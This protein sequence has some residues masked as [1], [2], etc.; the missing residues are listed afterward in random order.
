MARSGEVVS[1]W[2]LLVDNFNTSALAFYDIPSRPLSENAKFQR[3]EQNELSGSRGA[4]F[5]LTGSI[6]VL[7]VVKLVYD[8]CAAPYGAG[9]SA[10]SARSGLWATN[11]FACLPAAHRANLC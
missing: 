3:S 6:C 9:D 4:C 7:F 10:Q 11:A 8:I 1:H 2:H 5:R